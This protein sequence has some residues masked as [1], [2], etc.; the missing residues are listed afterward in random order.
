MKTYHLQL[1]NL[2]HMDLLL[3][4]QLN[5]LKMNKVIIYDYINIQNL[6]AYK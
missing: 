1:L 2:V 4:Y 6:N 5:H 3:L